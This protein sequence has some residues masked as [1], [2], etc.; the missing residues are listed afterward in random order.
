MFKE[1]KYPTSLYKKIL[2]LRAVEIFNFKSVN[3]NIY[4]DLRNKTLNYKN[5]VNLYMRRSVD[6]N[7]NKIIALNLNVIY[8]K[9]YDK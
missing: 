8:K 1:K 2:N 7:P 9:Y 5:Y 4:R 6:E 3:K